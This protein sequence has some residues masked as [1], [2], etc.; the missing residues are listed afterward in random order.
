MVA[1]T[2]K[3]G[4]WTSCRKNLG[5]SN[6]HQRLASAH[7]GDDCNR[8]GF[9]ELLDRPGNRDSLGRKRLAQKRS[10]DRRNRVAG[11]VQGREAG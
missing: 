5:D 9:L 11:C 8:V 7:F 2:E 4:V 3:T 6:G 10:Q 1:M